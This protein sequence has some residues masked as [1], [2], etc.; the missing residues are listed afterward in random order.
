MVESKN[1]TT[2]ENSAVANS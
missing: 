1:P 2:E